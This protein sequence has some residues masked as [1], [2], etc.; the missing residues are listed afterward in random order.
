VKFAD[1]RP[2]SLDRVRPGDQLRARGVKS[3]D[4]VRVDAEEIVFGTFVT[5]AGTVTAV[6]VENQRVTLKELGTNEVL[7]VMLNPDSQLK[8]MPS[9]GEM[10]GGGGLAA[11]GGPWAGRPGGQ[12]PAGQGPGAAAGGQ[13][14]APG[15]GMGPGMRAGGGAPDLT[16][17]LERMPSIGL[18]KLQTGETIVVSSTVGA[19]KN[20]LT[21]IIVLSNAGTLVQMA[22]AQAAASAARGQASAAAAPNLGGLATGLTGLDLSGF[23]Q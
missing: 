3:E 16:Q 20:E 21:A 19:K 5:R 11:A 15:A 7:A 18:D 1:A 4:G 13:R 9:F 23:A 8:Q 22:Q 10:A 17:M 12:G 14:L 2:S 6:D